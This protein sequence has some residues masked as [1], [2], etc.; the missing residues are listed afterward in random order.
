MPILC[1]LFYK[2]NEMKE[3]M[4]LRAR[5]GYDNFLWSFCLFVN[6]VLPIDASGRPFCVA[7]ADGDLLYL[8]KAI[9]FF[10]RLNLAQERGDEGQTKTMRRTYCCVRKIPKKKRFRP[11]PLLHPL[12][13][14]LRPA[15]ARNMSSI[16]CCLQHGQRASLPPRLLESQAT[17][18]CSWK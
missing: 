5:C 1:A 10:R 11:L 2:S 18:Q 9:E 4:A 12:Y 13:L 6:E 3:V 16:K 8:S 17:I 14:L 7:L 15:W